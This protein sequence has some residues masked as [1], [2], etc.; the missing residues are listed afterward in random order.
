M[1]PS[2][3]NS[4]IQLAIVMSV[5]GVGF[6]CTRLLIAY[7]EARSEDEIEI[8]DPQGHK[9]RIKLNPKTGSKAQAQEQA[10][11]LLGM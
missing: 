3:L 7:L 6:V 11:T 2:L 8:T 4:V 9:H 10:R 5:L 1:L